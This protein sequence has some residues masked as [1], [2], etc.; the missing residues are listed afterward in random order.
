MGFSSKK[1]L[2]I[3][4]FSILWQ[5]TIFSQLLVSLKVLNHSI[6]NLEESQMHA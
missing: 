5:L 2:S 4:L 1:F 6:T 3:D